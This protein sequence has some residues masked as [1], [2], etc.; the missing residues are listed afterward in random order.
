MYKFFFRVAKVYQEQEYVIAVSD[1][2]D[3]GDYVDGETIELHTPTGKVFNAESC[4]VLYD[5]LGDHSIALAFKDL[6]LTDI[7]VGTEVWLNE[8]R[9]A[10]QPSRHY[11]AREQNYS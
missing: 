2:S 11:E 5:Q 4:E 6:Q 1:R 3:F 8:S 7:P 10:R 9:P